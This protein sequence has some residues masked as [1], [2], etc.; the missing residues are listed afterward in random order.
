MRPAQ[1]CAQHL[2]LLSLLLVTMVVVLVA[3][4]VE[5]EFSNQPGPPPGQESL[6]DYEQLPAAGTAVECEST[7]MCVC[8]S[9]FLSSLPRVCGDVALL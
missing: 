6:S 7:N 4:R 1:L 8:I 9:P 2:M 5:G 3:H